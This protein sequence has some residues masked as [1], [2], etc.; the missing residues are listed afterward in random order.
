MWILDKSKQL[1]EIGKHN[2]LSV[3]ILVILLAFVAYLIV[4]VYDLLMVPKYKPRNRHIMMI[5]YFT[6]SNPNYNKELALYT[7]LGKA[8]KQEYLELS[9][10]EKFK[11]YESKLK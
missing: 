5:D 3:V 8:K 4:E 6:Q 7:S 10:D 11:K 2:P 9:R 1:I